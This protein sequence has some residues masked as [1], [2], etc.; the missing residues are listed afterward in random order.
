MESKEKQS[1]PTYI[2]DGYTRS[3][4]IRAIPG[5]HGQIRFSYRPMLHGKRDSVRNGYQRERGEKGSL[6]VAG[7]I[8]DHLVEWVCLYPEDGPDELLRGKAVKVTVD[9][10]RHLAPPL[11]DRM[12][13]IVSGMDGSDPEPEAEPEEQKEYAEL[14]LQSAETG[15]GPGALQLAEQQKN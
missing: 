11:L 5:L 15:I 2:P 10:V 8:A 4:F 7:A 6:L 9:S 1:A 3:G 12:F 14:L 13:S